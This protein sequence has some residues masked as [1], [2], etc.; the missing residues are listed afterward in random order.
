MQKTAL[1]AASIVSRQSFF[2]S[3]SGTASNPLAPAVQEVR[4][5]ESEVTAAQNVIEAHGK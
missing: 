2:T 4:F 3:V 1:D 5:C